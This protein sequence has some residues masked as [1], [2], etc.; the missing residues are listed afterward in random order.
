M[1]GFLSHYKDAIKLRDGIWVEIEGTITKGT[2][3][4]SNMPILE[5]TSLKE[6]DKPN[7]EYVEPPDEDYFP[8]V[9]MY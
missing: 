3:H 1:F 7:D 9:A 2:Y 4:G 5:I 8:T 6:I